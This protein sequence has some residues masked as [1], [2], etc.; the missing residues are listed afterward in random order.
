L[1]R[2]D[3]PDEYLEDLKDMDIPVGGGS[4]RAV[5]KSQEK[6]KLK[7]RIVIIPLDGLRLAAGMRSD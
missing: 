3:L 5:R 2:V 1:I 4:K 7:A 6:A